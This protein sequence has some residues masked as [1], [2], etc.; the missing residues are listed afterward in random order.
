[1]AEV[2]K[3]HRGEPGA[4]GRFDE[5]TSSRVAE[6]GLVCILDWSTQKYHLKLLGE[7]DLFLGLVI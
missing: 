2:R 5:Q 7:E 3:E 1:M 6:P 4:G